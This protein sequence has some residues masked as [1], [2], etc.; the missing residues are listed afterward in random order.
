MYMLQ[1]IS[2]DIR[3]ITY[4]S[5]SQSIDATQTIKLAFYG[6]QKNNDTTMAEWRLLMVLTCKSVQVY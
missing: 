6:E 3:N 2:H 5:I 1:P 4:A